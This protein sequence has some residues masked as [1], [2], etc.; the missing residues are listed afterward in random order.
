ML[1]SL[2]F[3][4]FFREDHQFRTEFDFRVRGNPNLEISEVTNY[5]AHWEW[6]FADRQNIS[7]ALFYKDLETP[8]ERVVQPASGTAD[9]SRTFRNLQ[10]AELYGVEVEGRKDFALS[11]DLSQS[12][13]VFVN[14]SVIESAASLADGTKRKLQGQPDYTVNRV[15]D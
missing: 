4:W 6:Y 9:N 15:L 8:V 1:P 14:A 7:V 5:D 13:F 2:D 11:D 3:N 12:I 10:S